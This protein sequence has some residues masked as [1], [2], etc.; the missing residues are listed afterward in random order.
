MGE[1]PGTAR[2]LRGLARDVL[3]PTSL[4]SLVQGAVL[5]VLAYT[6]TGLGASVGAAALVVACVGLGQLLGS[7]PAGLLATRLGD[8]RA[9]VL[10]ALLSCACWAVASV[11]PSLPVLVVAALLGG[12]SFAASNVAR[13]SYVVEVVPVARRARVMSVIGGAG[14]VGQVLGAARRRG[15][16]GRPRAAR[17]LP[18]RGGGRRDERLLLTGR[19]RRPATTGKRAGAPPRAPLASVARLHRRA[20]VLLGSGAA[21]IAAARGARPVL[22]PL[23]AVAAGASPQVTSLLFALTAVTELLLVYPAGAAMDRYGRVWVAAPCALLLGTGMLLLPLATTT[24]RLAAVAVLLGIGSGLGAGI[25]KTLGADA[26]PS[27]DRTTFLGLWALVGE[28]GSAGGPL[29]AGGLA[30]LVS[31][32]AS[33]LVL[34]GASVL[35]AAWLAR[36]VPRWD[37]RHA[38]VSRQVQ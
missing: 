18:R 26:S 33:A 20:L 37:P 10:A 2:L 35:G 31:V 14:R 28:A 4:T 9:M 15:G 3:V 25:V 24:A 12:S 8:A 23:F 16:A 21:V 19:A 5:P 11:A 29:A 32:D 17:L 22:L 36:Q 13:Q 6:A 30:G 1:A 27:A 34:G 7:A 38:P